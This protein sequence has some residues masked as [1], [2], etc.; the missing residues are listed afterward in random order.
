MTY[1]NTGGKLYINGIGGTGTLRSEWSVYINGFLK[2]KRRISTA[3]ANLEIPFN[4]YLVNNGEL[5][6]VKV[7]HFEDISGEFAADL[8]FN[9]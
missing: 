8:R 3:E 1:N 2:A 9:R 5:V 7:E 6:V 4:S